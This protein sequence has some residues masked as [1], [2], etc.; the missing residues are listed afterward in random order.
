ME[1]LITIGGYKLPEPSSYSAVTSTIVDSARNVQ[2]KVVGAVVRSDLAKIE[3]S[4]KYLTVKQ[5]AEILSLFTSSFY[6]DV[7]FLNQ[8]TGA[9]DVRTMYVSD[10]RASAWRRDPVTGEVLGWVGPSLSLVEV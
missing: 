1:A 7:R 2:G 5:W 8:A 6:N 3:V 4:W 9:Y 10:R